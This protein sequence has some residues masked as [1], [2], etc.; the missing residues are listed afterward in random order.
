VK[1]YFERITNAP[2]GQPIR[3]TIEQAYNIFADFERSLVERLLQYLL[4]KSDITVLG[5]RST[6]NR[7]PTI[8]FTSSRLSARDI[9]KHLNAHK[10]AC[11]NGNMYAY[12]LVNALEIDINDGVVRLSAVHYNTMAEMDKCIQV[13]DDIL[14]NSDNDVAASQT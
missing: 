4:T 10:I 6:V 12:R 14:S 2:Q 3:K 11:R 8:S 13:L 1:S 7:L 9:V 5:P